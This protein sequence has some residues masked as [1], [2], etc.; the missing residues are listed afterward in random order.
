MGHRLFGN[1]GGDMVPPVWRGNRQR[2]AMR[3]EA[4]EDWGKSPAL[5]RSRVNPG[6]KK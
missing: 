5:I 1:G 3:R 6:A 2:P 4:E